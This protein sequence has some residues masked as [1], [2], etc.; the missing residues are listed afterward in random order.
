ME[1]HGD[2]WARKGSTLSDKTA[3]AEFGLTQDEIIAADQGGKAA[4]PVCCDARKPV[5]AGRSAVRSR[6][7]SA[8][9][10][11]SGT[12]GNGRRGLS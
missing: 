7:W 3:R 12:S 10:M 1:L 5:A 4:V 8:A 6:I 9:S 11:V 2:E